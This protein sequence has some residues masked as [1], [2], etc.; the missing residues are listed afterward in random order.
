M[1]LYKTEV[2]NSISS[3]FRTLFS[4]ITNEIN[5]YFFY[6]SKS[7]EISLFSFRCSC[8]PKRFVERVEWL[9]LVRPCFKSVMTK[10]RLG[11]V[12]FAERDFR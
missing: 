3:D 6:L 4:V 8:T 2:M 5:P 1:S 10:D 7:I 9:F 12:F 11:Y